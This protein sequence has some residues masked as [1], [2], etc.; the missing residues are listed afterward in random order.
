MDLLEETIQNDYPQFS[1]L[2]LEKY[3]RQLYG[4]KERVTKVS[5]WWD[6]HGENEIDLIALEQLDHRATVAEVKRNPM[7]YDPKTLALKYEQIKKHLKDYN[8]SLIGLSM[9][10]M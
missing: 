1:G 3:F 5:H 7:K 2:V 10:D 8:V 6:S 9:N 4:E